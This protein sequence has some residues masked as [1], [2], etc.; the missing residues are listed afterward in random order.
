MAGAYLLPDNSVT[1]PVLVGKDQLPVYISIR[2]RNTKVLDFVQ[3]GKP[4]LTVDRT[5]FEVWLGAL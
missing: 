3:F 2:N 4:I 5:I 1:E